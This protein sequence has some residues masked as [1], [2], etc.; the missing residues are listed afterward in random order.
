M[1]VV[2]GCY[3]LLLFLF[4]GLII[5]FLCD[6][7]YLPHHWPADLF[8]LHNH[9]LQSDSLSFFLS[10]LL[11]SMYFSAI[12]LHSIMFYCLVISKW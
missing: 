3:N 5:S 2:G 9:F 4:F 11:T 10:F 8:T 6:Y 7:S 12:L 1:A